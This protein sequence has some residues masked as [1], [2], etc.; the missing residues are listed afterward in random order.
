MKVGV[1]QLALDLFGDPA[2]QNFASEF[3][4]A[5]L[6]LGRGCQNLLQP[7]PDMLE[8]MSVNFS[9]LAEFLSLDIPN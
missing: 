4:R 8:N 1:S 6:D 9:K 3:K 7:R 2:F 5:R